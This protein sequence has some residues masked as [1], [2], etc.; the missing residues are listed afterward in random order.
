MSTR[1]VYKR[2]RRSTV[3][4][5][6]LLDLLFVMV[7]VSL[8]QQ[9]EIPAPTPPPVKKII[10]RPAKKM[11]ARPVTRP[12]RM[13][14]EAEFEFY[15]IDQ[16]QYAASGKY[17]MLGTFVRDSGVLNLV[18]E[19]WIDKPAGYDMVPLLGSID[20]N[21]PDIFKGRIQSAGCL[22]FTLKRVGAK[23]SEIYKGSWEGEYTCGQGKTGLV[24]TIK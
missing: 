19:R 24:L 3:Q 22:N 11:E 12:N 13:T 2:S 14:V 7:F 9:K 23:T 21:N 6:S 4:L 8:L 15:P 1:R 20:K 16:S 5:T 10:S 17:I 18:G